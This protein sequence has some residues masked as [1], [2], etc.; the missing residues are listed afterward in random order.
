MYQYQKFVLLSVFLLFIQQTSESPVEKTRKIKPEKVDLNVEVF[1]VTNSSCINNVLN[2]I[3]K[4]LMTR[5]IINLGLFSIEPV[6]N[7]KEVKGRSLSKIWKIISNNALRVPFGDY[8]LTLQKSQEYEN[9]MDVSIGKVVEGRGPFERKQLQFFVPAFLV[10]SQAG[11]WLLALAGV[12]ILSTKAFIV[13]KL[14]LSIGVILT[15]RKMFENYY[16]ITQYYEPQEPM[17]VPYNYDISGYS[18][19]SGFPNEFHPSFQIGPEHTAALHSNGALG[20][21][22]NHVVTNITGNHVTPPLLT[23]SFTTIARHPS[24]NFNYLA[25]SPYLFRKP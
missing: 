8:S 10:A 17:M 16:G 13:A 6:K 25:K 20:S 4:A 2:K 21:E 3:V 24:V 5:K 1:C 7:I 15:L 23:S 22:S 12:T 19:P 9:F 11:W 18:G 14:A